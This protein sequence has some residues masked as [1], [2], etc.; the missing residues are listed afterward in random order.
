MTIVL[1]LTSTVITLSLPTITALSHNKPFIPSNESI[2]ANALINN[3]TFCFNEMLTRSIPTQRA[4]DSL[5]EAN[6]LY[7]AQFSLEK[8]NKKADYKLVINYAEAVC[9]IKDNSIKANDE[10]KIFKEAYEE[11]KQRSNLSAMEQN[12][13]KILLTFNEE[14]FEETIQLINQGYET[15]TEIEASQT[16]LKLFYETTTRTIKDF[17]KENWKLLSII[18]GTTI[19][20]LIIFWTTLKRIRIKLKIRNLEIQKNSLNELIKKLQYDYFKTKKLSETEFRVKLQTFK[21]MIRDIDRQI[22]LLKEEIMKLGK[23]NISKRTKEHI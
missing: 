19:I 8:Q 4:N 10:L 2:H 16:T 9:K 12:Y 15:L 23:A 14:R 17:F 6:Q 18:T 7:S 20:L 22:P 1:L 11:A 5:Q 21:E 13:Q 3:A